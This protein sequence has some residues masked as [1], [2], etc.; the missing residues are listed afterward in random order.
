MLQAPGLVTVARNIAASQLARTKS[1]A[2]TG[3][4]VV[5]QTRGLQCSAKL[6]F[7][8]LE[9]SWGRFF[10]RRLVYNVIVVQADFEE[11]SLSCLAIGRD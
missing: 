6:P 4:R 1:R 11:G 7:C 9:D 5:Q 3:R 8:L 10:L 2:S